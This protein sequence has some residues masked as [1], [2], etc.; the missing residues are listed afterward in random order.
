MGRPGPS[1]IEKDF[2]KEVHDQGQTLPDPDEVFAE[3][4]EDPTFPIIP[5]Q[6]QSYTL[7]RE[8]SVARDQKNGAS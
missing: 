8:Q 2:P 4:N 7:V 5:Q 6:E 3:N 1:G